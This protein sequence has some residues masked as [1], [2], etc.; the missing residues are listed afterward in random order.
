MAISIN[1]ETLSYFK[2]GY[3]GEELRSLFINYTDTKNIDLIQIIDLRFEVDQVNLKKI[4]L[5][6]KNRVSTKIA[7]LFTIILRY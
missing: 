7:K 5:F 6:E 2:K 1:L 4:Q 3:V